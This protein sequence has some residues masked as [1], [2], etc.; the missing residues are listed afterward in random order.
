MF[1]YKNKKFIRKLLSTETQKNKYQNQ[2]KLVS[3]GIHKLD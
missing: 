3:L 2:Q 1:Q